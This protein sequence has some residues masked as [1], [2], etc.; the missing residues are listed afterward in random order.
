MV[1]QLLE[2]HAG[3]RIL[4]AEDNEVNREIA[5]AM[6]EGVGLGA[7]SAANGVEALRLARAG[8]YDLVLMDMQMPEMG[9][10]EATRALRQLPG[11]QSVPILALTANAFEDDRRACTDA[12]MNGF[13][14]K[15]IAVGQFYAALLHWLDG[16]DAKVSEPDQDTLT[17]PTSMSHKA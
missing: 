12:G 13:I 5:L 8:P 1:A 15:P 11:W 3:A 7:E 9:G 16:P 2:R 10:L 17:R 14:V 4:L 6:L